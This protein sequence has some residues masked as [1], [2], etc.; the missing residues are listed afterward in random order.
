[1][2]FVKGLSVKEALKMFA[3]FS[4]R[5]TRPQPVSSSRCALLREA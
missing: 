5:T 1:V 2:T 3:L 4:E